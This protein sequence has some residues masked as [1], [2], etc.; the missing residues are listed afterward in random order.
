[1]RRN[2]TVNNALAANLGIRKKSNLM[3][4]FIGRR[5]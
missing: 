2:N 5:I 4:D 3:P 1:M